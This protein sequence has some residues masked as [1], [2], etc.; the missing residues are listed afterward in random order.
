M[1]RLVES[2]RHVALGPV[3][4]GVIGV[5][6]SKGSLINTG[7]QC[8]TWTWARESSSGQR[9]S[10]KWSLSL[11]IQVQEKSNGY[12]SKCVQKQPNFYTCG[13]SKPVKVYILFFVVFLY[14]WEDNNNTK[15]AQVWNG[16]PFFL[17]HPQ[18]AGFV[19]TSV[20]IVLF[21]HFFEVV[22]LLVF[23]RNHFL[24]GF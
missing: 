12:A 14:Y 13:R 23:I 8:W 9:H 18:R 5:I 21:D 20:I 2:S 6:S 19:H 17:H 3:L 15:D 11:K 10:S 1:R 16:C 24:C 7:M 22:L 4:S